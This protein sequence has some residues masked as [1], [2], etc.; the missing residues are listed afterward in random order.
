[1][2]NNA[3]PILQKQNM[4]PDNAENYYLNLVCTAGKNFLTYN[5]RSKVYTMFNRLLRSEFICLIS[6]EQLNNFKRLISLSNYCQDCKP[7]H[8]WC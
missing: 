5:I 3:M 4:Q 1:M 7:N 8:Y 2:G 6:A